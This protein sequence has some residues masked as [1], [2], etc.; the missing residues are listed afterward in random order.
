MLSLLGFLSVK[1]LVKTSECFA[2]RETYAQDGRI[3]VG[4]AMPRVRRSCVEVLD[5]AVSMCDERRCMKDAQV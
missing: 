2:G 3:V 1:Y 5:R 4:C